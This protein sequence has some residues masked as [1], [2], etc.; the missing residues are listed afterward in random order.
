MIPGKLRLPA[1]DFPRR[2][3]RTVV[4]QIFTVKIS[5]NTL[6]HNRFAVIVSTAAEKRAVYRNRARRKILGVTRTWPNIGQEIIFIVAKKFKGTSNA[7]MHGELKK[8][9]QTAAQ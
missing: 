4:S 5:K 2:P 3:D 9:L 6:T 8:V 7:D 1:K